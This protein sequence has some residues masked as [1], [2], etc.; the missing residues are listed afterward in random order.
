MPIMQQIPRWIKGLEPL[1][2]TN[3]KNENKIAR[4]DGI[5]DESP[6][7]RTDKGL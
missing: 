1:T 3:L 5:P 7:V 2:R 4:K 6:G